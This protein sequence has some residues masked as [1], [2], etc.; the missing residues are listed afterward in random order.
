M[1]KKL[2]FTLLLATPALH[3]LA[4]L[5]TSE[6][7]K[8]YFIEAEKRFNDNDY[9]TALEYIGKTENELGETNGRIL[10]LKIK[11]LYNFGDLRGAQD[12]LNIFI[13]EYASTVT[14][15]IKDET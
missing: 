8:L 12:A 13:N 3:V 4:Q 6:I 14:P 1:M 9:T 2:L 5:K 7:A 15:E 10:N 11:T